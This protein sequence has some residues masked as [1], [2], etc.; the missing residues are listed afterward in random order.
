MLVN[1]ENRKCLRNVKDIHGE[2]QHRLEVGDVDKKN[3]QSDKKGQEGEKKGMEVEGGGN[4]SHI[5]E[6]GR[7]TSKK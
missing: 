5:L 3:C 2:L 1:Q 6:K 4:S 7:R